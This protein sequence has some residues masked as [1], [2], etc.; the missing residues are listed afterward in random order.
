[1]YD[2]TNI[3]IGDCST[4][5]TDELYSLLAGVY[6]CKAVY[7]PANQTTFN[8]KFSEA[9]LPACLPGALAQSTD[10]WPPYQRYENN[11]MRSN[12]ACYVNSSLVVELVSL[13]V[14][15]VRN[16]SRVVL[17]YINS[18]LNDAKVSYSSGDVQV[19]GSIYP[20]SP[21]VRVSA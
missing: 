11:I 7:L 15:V 5:S 12:F 10:L 6:R 21:S 4:H 8:V 14:S 20:L 17:A 13:E 19:A 1:M 3:Y 18:Y 2:R 16:G 9:R